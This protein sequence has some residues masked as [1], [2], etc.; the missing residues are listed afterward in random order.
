VRFEPLGA[1]GP[2]IPPAGPDGC[3]ASGRGPVSRACYFEPVAQ[4]QTL[5]SALLVAMPQLEDPN[6]S[7]TVMLIV[8][9]DEGGTFG[10][11]LNRSVDLLAST[12]CASLDVK[13]RGDPDANI[14][15]GGPVEP[16]SGWLLLNEPKSID[17][18]DPAVS[19]VGGENLFLARSVEI[20]RC[21][22]SESPGD[23]RFFLGY[24]GWGPGQLEYEMS[25]GAWLVAPPNC[26][27]VFKSSNDSMW[28]ETVRSLGIEPASLV[29]TQGVH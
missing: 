4:E 24:A 8:E 23:I 16:N 6:F 26:A 21:A 7:R 17:L 11:V 1:N 22:S 5:T 27:A 3:I 18:D 13:W 20:L 15:W 29:S 14:Q 25:Q 10:L 2:L 9:H 28:D 12:L 19:Q